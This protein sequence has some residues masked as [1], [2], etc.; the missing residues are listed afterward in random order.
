MAEVPRHDRGAQAWQQEAGQLFTKFLEDAAGLA[1][2][3]GDKPGG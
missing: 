2:Y 1:W 3:C